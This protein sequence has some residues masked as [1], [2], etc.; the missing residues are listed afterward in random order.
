MVRCKPLLHLV[1]L[2][3]YAVATCASAQI[4]QPVLEVDFTTATVPLSPALSVAIAVAIAVAAL[5]VLRRTRGGA[6]VISWVVVLASL[7]LGYALMHT[8]IISEAQAMPTPSIVLPLTSSPV[9]ATGYAY[10]DYIEAVNAT[11]SRITIVAVKYDPGGYDY[12]L[13]TATTTCVPGVALAPGQFCFI[14]IL[15][16]G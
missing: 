5:F 8:P 14:R 1:T 6:R 7:P 12:Y 16:L 9:I 3:V 15:S 4:A 10:F 11:N 2:V 13:D